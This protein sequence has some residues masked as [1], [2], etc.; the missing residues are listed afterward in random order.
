MKS[1]SIVITTYQNPEELKKCIASVTDHTKV[2]YEIIIEDGSLE[3]GGLPKANNEGIKRSHGDYILFLNDD[4]EIIRDGWLKVMIDE[5]K[6]DSKI[7]IVG[8]T[9]YVMGQ[10]TKYDWTLFWCVLIKREVF[11]NIGLFDEGFGMGLND[12]L[13]FCIRAQK[14]GYRIVAPSSPFKLTY[15]KHIGGVTFERLGRKEIKE[16]ADKYFNEKWDKNLDLRL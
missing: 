16:K 7:G 4:A 2:P 1:V 11:E 3:A 6:G 8:P 12:D 9:V 15:V 10:N 5:F 13:D 14:M